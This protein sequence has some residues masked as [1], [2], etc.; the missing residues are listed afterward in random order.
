MCVPCEPRPNMQFMFLLWTKN[1]I[2][3]LRQTKEGIIIFQTGE[4]AGWGRDKLRVHFVALCQEKN[5][6]SSFQYERDDFV[7]TFC[8]RKVTVIQG[9][10]Y[11][12]IPRWYIK[13]CHCWKTTI[14]HMNWIP[15]PTQEAP[16]MAFVDWDQATVDCCKW[17]SR[18]ST[19]VWWFKGNFKKISRALV[20]LTRW[21]RRPISPNRELLMKTALKQVS[22]SG[23]T[24]SNRRPQ[25]R[26]IRMFS[27]FGGST[28]KMSFRMNWTGILQQRNDWTMLGRAKGYICFTLNLR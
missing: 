4:Y 16:T 27:T 10:F 17:Y 15:A 19:L 26:N 2:R 11:K 14:Y 3:I 1:E 6:S 12:K 9:N 21:N 8:A 18:D 24:Y 5:A 23:S 28:T 13:N 22:E 7:F 20:L 25:Y